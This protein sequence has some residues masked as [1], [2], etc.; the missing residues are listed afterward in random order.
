LLN[1][2]MDLS[3]EERKRQLKEL[4]RMIPRKAEIPDVLKDFA[5]LLSRQKKNDAVNVHLLRHLR[6][7]CS[8]R[9][10]PTFRCAGILVEKSRSGLDPPY[11][12]DTP[13]PSKTVE[14]RTK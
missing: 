14:D 5:R 3:L 4:L 10:E 6:V 2:G 8:R 12:P 11:R 9:G 1:P 7:G 13:S